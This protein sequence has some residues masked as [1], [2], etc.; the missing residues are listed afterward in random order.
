VEEVQPEKNPHFK[1]PAELLFSSSGSN[2]V[3][4]HDELLEVQVAVTVRIK[5]PEQISL[6][7]FLDCTDTDACGNGRAFKDVSIK[8]V[9]TYRT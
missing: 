7:S 1:S 5:G 6:D 3:V 4:G 9:V 2:E 8:L